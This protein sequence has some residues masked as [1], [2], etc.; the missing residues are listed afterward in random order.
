MLMK[1]DIIFGWVDIDMNTIIERS[2]TWFEENGFL[3]PHN[4]RMGQCGHLYYIFVAQD[5]VIKARLGNYLRYCKGI[6]IEHKQLSIWA[7][8]Y[9]KYVRGFYEYIKRDIYYKNEQT[10]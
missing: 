1:R 4:I 6:D 9:V 10:G 7:N 2:N 5:K 3:I 8:D